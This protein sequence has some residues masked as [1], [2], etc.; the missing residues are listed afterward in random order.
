MRGSVT[1]PLRGEVSGLGK[2]KKSADPRDF[3]SQ[4]T[5]SARSVYRGADRGLSLLP[6]LR[7]SHPPPRAASRGTH[8]TQPHSRSGPAAAP[9]VPVTRKSAGPT[10]A[11][12]HASPAWSR[13][14]CKA[15]VPDPH[16]HTAQ[17]SLSSRARR[18]GCCARSIHTARFRAWAWRRHPWICERTRYNPLRTGFSLSHTGFSRSMA[19]AQPT[20]TVC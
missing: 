12:F 10:R 9:S 16:T 5:R 17:R 20:H 13:A 14:L 4:A 6:R 19:H 11:P 1:T 3:F 18:T 7:I 2:G 15:P 8:M